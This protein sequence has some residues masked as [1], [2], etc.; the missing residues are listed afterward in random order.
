MGSTTYINKNEMLIRI[1]QM[2]V[3]MKGGYIT[4][5]YITTA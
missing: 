2:Q 4:N 5:G 1:Q 3:Q